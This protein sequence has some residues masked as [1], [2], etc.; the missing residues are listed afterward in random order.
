MYSV[1][2]DFLSCDDPL[3]LAAFSKFVL[4]SNEGLAVLKI[5]LSERETP[6]LDVF[7][8]ISSLQSQTF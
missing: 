8:V 6:C 5:I 7:F 1:P 2:F 3:D 4:I